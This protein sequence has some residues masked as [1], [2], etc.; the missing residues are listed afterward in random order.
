MIYVWIGAAM[1][2]SSV[3][4]WIRATLEKKGYIRS[5]ED[6]EDFIKKT[7]SGVTKFN[8]WM[9][10]HGLRYDREKYCWVID[11]SP[12]SG[13]DHFHPPRAPSSHIEL[14]NYR[15]IWDQIQQTPS[16]AEA[17][18]ETNIS[19]NKLNKINSMLEE[20]WVEGYLEDWLRVIEKLLQIQIQRGSDHKSDRLM[21]ELRQFFVEYVRD[22]ENHDPPT[23][24]D[25]EWIYQE[26]LKDFSS[27]QNTNDSPSEPKIKLTKIEQIIN[28]AGKDNFAKNQGAWGS[29][30]KACGTL[31]NCG[32]KMGM[33]KS[34]SG[35][36]N[37]INRMYT[38]GVIRAYPQV[39]IQCLF[40]DDFLEEISQVYK[41]E[42]GEKM[43]CSPILI[44]VSEDQNNE[45]RP[46]RI[47]VQHQHPLLPLNQVE[48]KNMF[49]LAEIV[50]TKTAPFEITDGWHDG[51]G[52]Y[53]DEED[54]PPLYFEI[55]MKSGVYA[56]A[57]YISDSRIVV[58]SGSTASMKDGGAWKNGR[59]LR[60]QLVSK[61]V[62]EEQSNGIF[63]FTEDVEFSSPSV[64]AS[65]VRAL[66]T[67]GRTAWKEV[68]TGKKLVEIFGRV[69]SPGS[70]PKKSDEINTSLKLQDSINEILELQEYYS[71][72]NTPEMESRGLLIRKIAP[73][74]I[75]GWITDFDDLHCKGSDGSGRKTRI[76]W[77]RIFNPL[78]SPSATSGWY[79]VYL[80]AFDGSSVYL[81]L[82]Q[83]TTILENGSF[84]PRSSEQLKERVNWARELLSM[85]NLW[86]RSHG[87]KWDSI[88]LRDDIKLGKGYERGNVWAFRYDKH[89]IP[90]DEK[91]REHVHVMVDLLERIYKAESKLF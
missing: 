37:A 49:P 24:E 88:D 76:P 25:I 36:D 86:K 32:W 31:T 74:I 15:W 10:H 30:E 54:S 5:I 35:K 68:G 16:L 77:L 18:R 19:Y 60:D 48:I 78:H 47:L 33:C 13:G 27:L 64:A 85:V 29:F 17:A 3:E 14:L 66:Q 90:S 40:I 9:K 62:L 52:Y 7:G 51:D 58:L 75:R 61:G 12:L 26:L 63:L 50:R 65:V 23:N 84:T 81:S 39:L 59:D 46:T 6:R 44:L 4:E 69:N 21:L 91:L 57:E 11:D 83:G 56:K 28:Q 2:E 71:S 8:K 55:S 89:N 42:F 34:S 45:W 82:N 53:E 1:V 80:F 38:T 22:P 73:S 87:L 41:N 67:N 20:Y 79:I 43:R 72:A 70:K